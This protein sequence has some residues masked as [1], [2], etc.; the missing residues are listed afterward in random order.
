MLCHGHLHGRHITQE[1]RDLGDRVQLVVVGGLEL[2]TSL[3]LVLQPCLEVSGRSITIVPPLAMSPAG[4][5]RGGIPKWLHFTGVWMG[6]PA[7]TLG[8]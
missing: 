8:G 7:V 3:G 6:C 2:T 5:M 1:F 4:S